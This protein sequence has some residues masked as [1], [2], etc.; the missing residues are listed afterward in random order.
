MNMINMKWT[1]FRNWPSS[2]THVFLA[3]YIL[4]D[5]NYRL[6][7]WPISQGK[8]NKLTGT[9]SPNRDR[10][11]R[12]L[13]LLPINVSVTRVSDINVSMYV[14]IVDNSFIHQV[15]S[16]S[17]IRFTF[18]FKIDQVERL[19]IYVEGDP[20]GSDMRAERIVANRPIWELSL[21]SSRLSLAYSAR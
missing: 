11:I 5:Q 12:L 16:C 13:V 4:I 20:Y 9:N 18:L 19:K 7:F 6:N 10:L 2:G 14:D 21:E 1:T 8:R 15:F 17:L 3:R